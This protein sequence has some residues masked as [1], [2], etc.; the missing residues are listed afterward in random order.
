[1][2][3]RRGEMLRRRE[4]VRKRR[5]MRMSEGEIAERIIVVG[6]VLVLFQSCRRL[7]MANGNERKRCGMW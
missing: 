1:V 5:K 2:R 6:G 4:G 7:G 3:R